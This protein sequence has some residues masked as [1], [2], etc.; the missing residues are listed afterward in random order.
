MNAEIE[1]NPDY[2]IISVDP[3]NVHKH[4]FFCFMSKR[5]A[6]GYQQKRDG[7][8]PALPRGWRLRSSTRWVVGTLPSLN[9][10]PVSTL[11]GR[12]MPPV[13]W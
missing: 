4:G 11:G 10:S 8:M 5:K 9:T 7:R 3:S 6:P 12:C 13:I 2:E 1:K